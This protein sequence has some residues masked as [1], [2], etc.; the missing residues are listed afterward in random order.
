MNA[1]STTGTRSILIIGA[2]GTVSSTIIAQLRSSTHR[3]V[4]LVRNPGKAQSLVQSGI[5]VRAG[6]LEQPWTLGDAFK[7]IDTV[8][9]LTP[10][11]PRAPEQS[12]NALHAA[13]GAGVRHIVRMSAFGAAHDAPAINGRLHALSD[14]ELIASGITYTIIK[15]HFFMQ[16]LLMAAPGMARDGVL[17]FALGE[18]RIAAIDTRDV[19]AFAAHVLTTPGHEGKQ[20]TL[21]GPDSITM[22]EVAA[23]F[24]GVTGRSIRYQ[25]V[26]VEVARQSV[27]DMGADA[28]SAHML[29]DYLA[30]Y[31]AGWGD[32]VTDD[33]SRVTGRQP[34]SIEQFALAHSL[35]VVA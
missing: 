12:S 17:Y 25:P 23:A 4:A 6:D 21:T 22:H 5:E 33:F 29:S 24:A 1:S 18:A 15:P 35:A 13:R 3:I 8:W 31:S 2:T 16:N 27:L 10:P 14:A 20:Y 30:A 26:P 11:G 9:L 28:W 32:R 34:G 19:A 7:G